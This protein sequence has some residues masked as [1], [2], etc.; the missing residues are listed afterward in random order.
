M[1][2]NQRA[3]ADP[4]ALTV[5]RT[6]RIAAPV[7]KVWAAITEPDHISRWFGRT[8]LIG[9]GVGAHGTITWPEGDA[10]PIRIE[11]IDPPRS[12]TYRWCNDDTARALDTVTNDAPSTVFTFT[13]EPT[14]YGTQLTVEETGFETSTN[15]AA[16]LES[17]RQG[18]DGELDKLVNLLE[19]GSR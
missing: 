3:V 1:T 11:A 12:V 2:T 14:P 17:H 18:W 6:I 15:P 8:V 9:E 16:N 4:D 19:G 7:D 13:L 5:R 10:V